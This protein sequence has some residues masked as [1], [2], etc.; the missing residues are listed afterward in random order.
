VSCAFQ[1]QL[2]VAADGR[3]FVVECQRRSGSVLVFGAT[4]R[5]L[6]REVL[7]DTPQL[8][9]ATYS[10]TPLWLPVSEPPESEEVVECDEATLTSLL[11]L[12]GSPHADVRLEGVRA[13]AAVA[14]FPANRAA[15]SRSRSL[16]HTLATV[17]CTTSRASAETVRC[18]A[19]LLAYLVASGPVPSSPPSSSSSSSTSSCVFERLAGTGCLASLVTLVCPHDLARIETRRHAARVLAACPASVLNVCLESRH[20][21][22]SPKRELIDLIRAP[23]RDSTLS[24]SLAT[25]A[26]LLVM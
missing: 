17:L 14:A 26:S 19:L 24:A 16:F 12:A 3:G 21:T 23:A 8:V 5:A 15:L 20:S 11:E 13:L 4:Y 25:L 10:G 7:A 1:L 6:M 18:A 9:R 22:A 2:F